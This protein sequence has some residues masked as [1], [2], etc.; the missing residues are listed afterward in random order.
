MV[1]TPD[2]TM[3][4]PVRGMKRHT[5]HA[6]LILVVI[7]VTYGWS[8]T[9][10]FV[11]D[12]RPIV[13]MNP[14]FDGSHGLLDVLRAE[15]TFQEFGQSTGYYRPL[16]YLSFYADSL[17]WGKN[18]VGFHAT[19][20]LL[21]ALVSLS[22]YALLSA[23]LGRRG[24]ALGA[25]L[26]FAVN[27][28]TVETVCFISGGRNT[29]LCALC[30]LL[31]LL[32]HRKGNMPLA[33]L[34]TLGAAASKE[35][36]LLVPLLLLLH[37]RIE[38]R[39]ARPLHRY[40]PHLLAVGCVLVARS[41]VVAGGGGLPP[42]GAATVLLAPE[43][44]LRYL[45]IMLLPLWGKVAYT[46]ATPEPLSLR[47]LLPLAGCA[48]LALAA[49]GQRKNRVMLF[50][51]SWFILFLLPAL[52]VATRYK[53]QMADRHAYLPAIGVVLAL[54]PLWKR[55]GSRVY[56][57]AA[58]VLVS[59][60]SIASSRDSGVWKNDGT[61]FQRMIMDEPRLDTGY[62]GLGQYYLGTG[63]IDRG[64]SWID[65][66]ESAG[67][68][69]PRVAGNIRLNMLTSHGESL[70][71]AGK[72]G[73]AERMFRRAL[74]L[75]RDFVPALVDL[76]GLLARRGDSGGAIDLFTRAARLQ[77]ENPVPHFNLSEAYRMRHDGESAE[78]ELREYRRLAGE[79]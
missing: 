56:G 8:V 73:E 54:A 71:A 3:S 66:G 55:E 53:S 39:E 17:L 1:E 34:C 7:A 2:F 51:L 24:T 4:G 20:L 18:P 13:V 23:L 77:P 59:A 30:V 75:D 29:L 21:H 65:R 9:N 63:D 46:I 50:G 43:L 62:T 6:L 78:R 69:H 64:L 41:L 19:S 16:T 27:P 10:G 35:F 12:D 47:F 11:W 68:L 67:A 32:M 28:V 70:S 33:V 45:G 58:C 60:F 5:L 74:Q 14:V 61:L 48:L 42:V 25:T 40:L 36:G 52:V 72:D 31:A 44:V 57:V 76:G 22:L 37:D 15:D 79:Q 38:A 49:F 26:L